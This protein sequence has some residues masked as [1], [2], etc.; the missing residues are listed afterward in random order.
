[1]KVTLDF[2]K[3][4]GGDRL[5]QFCDFGRGSHPP[6]YF[7]LRRSFR[8]SRFIRLNLCTSNLLLI[9]L[10]FTVLEHFF[11]RMVAFGLHA[12]CQQFDGSAD[13]RAGTRGAELILFEALVQL[14]QLERP[15]L[16]SHVCESLVSVQVQGV[17]LCHLE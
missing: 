17:P 11:L 15:L 16:V 9:R 4:L 7:V 13:L 3:E 10:A 12:E 2:G 5:F 1:M 8:R 14:G 6:F